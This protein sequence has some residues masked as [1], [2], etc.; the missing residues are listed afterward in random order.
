VELL[1][2]FSSALLL[3][4]SISATELFLLPGRILEELI[5]L[6]LELFRFLG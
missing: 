6:A 1:S 2:I 3:P 5:T 4:G